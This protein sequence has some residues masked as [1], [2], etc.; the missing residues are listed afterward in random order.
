V[1]LSEEL[2]AVHCSFAFVHDY[3]VLKAAEE[4]WKVAEG[5]WKVAEGVWK[6]AEEVWK[7][8]VE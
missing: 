6:V 2:P 1:T 7:V 4:V 3:P 5:V 8:A